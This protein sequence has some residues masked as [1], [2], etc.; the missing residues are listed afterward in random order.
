M[1][2]NKKQYPEIKAGYLVHRESG[3]GFVN[4]NSVP[5]ALAVKDGNALGLVSKVGTKELSDY[6]LVVSWKSLKHLAHRIKNNQF[7]PFLGLSVKNKD[8]DKGA[9]VMRISSDSPFSKY[10]H[11]GDVIKKINGE[12]IVDS[13][14]VLRLIAFSDKK[15]E[16]TVDYEGKERSFTLEL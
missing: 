16:F 12:E 4:Q 8:N 10:L 5:G 11:L 9:F 2:I 14:D 7:A 3:F 1:L 6:S 15:V 13:R